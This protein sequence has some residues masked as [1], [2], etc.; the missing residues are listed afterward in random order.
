MATNDVIT[1]QTNGPMGCFVRFAA[2]KNTNPARTAVVRPSRFSVIR[3]V[4]W[5]FGASCFPRH[6]L[7]QKA[8]LPVARTSL[9]SL[10]A[11]VIRSLRRVR[12]WG[13][14]SASHGG[15]LPPPPEGPLTHRTGR[16]RSPVHPRDSPVNP[17][18]A[19]RDPR[20]APMSAL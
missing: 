8:V 2:F 10:D 1:Y 5:S 7:S 9:C 11:A 6:P 15:T 16:A 4:S 14:A 18:D 20:R 19:P 12:A 3:C 17:V 13:A